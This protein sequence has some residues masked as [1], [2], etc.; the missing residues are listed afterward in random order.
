MSINRKPIVVGNWKMNLSLSEA[1]GLAYELSEQLE[2]IAGVDIDVGIAPSTPF[3]S[4]IAAIC[5][6]SAIGI[7]AQHMSAHLSGAHTGESSVQQLL[8]VG[9]QYV[10]LGHSERRHVYGE[11][12]EQIAQCARL[13]HDLGL[14]P[15]LC[16]GET[17]QQREANQTLD[18]VLKQVSSAFSQLTADEASRSIC[19][20]EPVWA[21]GTGH[22]ASP[23][24]AQEVHAAIR[25][26]LSE[27]YSVAIADSV[28]LQY[29]G[30][31][32]PENAEG[33]MSQPDIDGALV[34]GASLKVNSFNSIV[35][36]TSKLISQ[37]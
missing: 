8:D 22:T 37:T 15:I 30:S 28:R 13:A 29:G 17:L 5:D 11:S 19:A 18:V 4:I 33:L 12:D 23:E 6:E 16:V 34:G 3:L 2:D 10:I 36:I 9:C 32:K 20:Y 27:L 25:K 1:T 26:H 21:I 7:S 31:V 24:Q 14:I 35:Q